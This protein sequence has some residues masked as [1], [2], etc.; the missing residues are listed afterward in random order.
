MYYVL[1]VRLMMRRR[2]NKLRWPNE[3]G[4]AILAGLLGTAAMTI[5]MIAMH[6]LLPREQ[7][8]P[9]PPRQITMAA[10]ERVG[11]KQH[12]DDEGDSRGHNA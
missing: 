5:A 10:A 3:L 11:I 4:T 2:Q 8:Q 1:E 12:G 9:L 6:K 7:Q